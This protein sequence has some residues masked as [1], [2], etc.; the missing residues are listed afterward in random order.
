MTMTLYVGNLPA[1]M[2]ET[3]LRDLFA[4]VGEVTRVILVSNRSANEPGNSNLAFVEMADTAA[5]RQAI[6]QLNGKAMEDRV[7][8]VADARSAATRSS[9]NRGRYTGV[10]RRRRDYGSRRVS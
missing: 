1:N 10:Y 4:Q 8:V 5:A 6:G 2:T 3:V 7:I 9:A